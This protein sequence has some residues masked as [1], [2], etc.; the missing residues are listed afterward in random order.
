MQSFC[1]LQLFYCNFHFFVLEYIKIHLG[2]IMKVF[3]NTCHEAI[4]CA[5]KN[6]TFGLY[7]SETTKP[8]LLIHMHDCCE[9]FFSLS[10]GNSFLIDDKVYSVNTN[11]LFIL[12]QFEAHKVTAYNNEK[13]IRYS[14]HIHPEFIHLNSTP[15]VN[16][17]KCFYSDQKLDRINLTDSEAQKLSKL[18]S[19]LSEDYG[20]G[21]DVYKKIRTIEIL[22]EI[23]KL[24]DTHHT[25]PN[26]LPS[27]KTLLLAIDYI[28]QNFAQQIS[29]E[30]VAKNCFVSVN[31][32]CS[33]FKKYL[34][35]T[36][37]KYIT[38]K[39]ITQAKKY[40]HEGKSVTETAFSCGFNDYANFI[41]VFKTNVGTSPGKY[42]L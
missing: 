5:I 7:Y 4:D 32:L 18:F 29:L 16:L 28:N 20:Y 34:Y 14:L 26:L 35:T 1:K 13:F 15:D 24:Y 22:L 39:R 37:N 30:D 19:T 6:K 8:N 38:S 11:D 42:K 25:T 2:A 36:V 40:L 41:R 21:D 3:F 33:L 9:V 17:Y 10:D 23:T 12:N 31:Q 27:N